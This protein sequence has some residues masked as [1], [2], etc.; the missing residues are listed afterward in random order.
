VVLCLSAAPSVSL[1]V[2]CGAGRDYFGFS[3]L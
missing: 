1:G 2:F 3:R